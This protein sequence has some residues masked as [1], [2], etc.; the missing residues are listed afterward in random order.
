MANG[1]ERIIS[2][3]DGNR[4]HRIVD[5][6]S[7]TGD[8]VLVP[9]ESEKKIRLFGGRLI[10][11][12]AS[13]LKLIEQDQANELSLENAIGAGEWTIPESEDFKTTTANKAL[14]LRS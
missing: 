12:A 7:G 4:T 9:A 14:N 11:D 10:V 6:V 2:R 1:T 13:E 5:I 3:R 8:A